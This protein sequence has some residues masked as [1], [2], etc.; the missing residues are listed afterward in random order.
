MTIDGIPGAGRGCCDHSAWKTWSQHGRVSIVRFV[1]WDHSWSSQTENEPLNNEN[2]VPIWTSFHYHVRFLVQ[3]GNLICT[4]IGQRELQT[5]S[6]PIKV[7]ITSTKEP[8]KNKNLNSF[9][10]LHPGMLFDL[11]LLC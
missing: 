9:T 5:Q 8:K 1:F 2:L 10:D 11:F 7:D 6:Y 3:S 4:V